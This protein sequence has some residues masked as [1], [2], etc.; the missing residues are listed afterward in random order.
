VVA[1]S[2]STTSRIQQLLEIQPPVVGFVHLLPTC[3]HGVCPNGEKVKMGG[4]EGKGVAFREC[5]EYLCSPSR[6]CC[7][8]S[9]RPEIDWKEALKLVAGAAGWP[10]DADS[11]MA[12]SEVTRVKPCD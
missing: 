3:C 5:S 10:Y 4:R 9:I 12:E 1:G 6:S 7:R 11:F 2:L 8:A